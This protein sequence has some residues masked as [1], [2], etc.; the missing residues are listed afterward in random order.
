MKAVFT[1]VAKNYIPLAKNLKESILKIHP[2]LDVFIFVTSYKDEKLESNS[3]LIFLEQLELIK[4][5][6]PNLAFKYNITEFCTSIKPACF[7]YLSTK[8]YEKIIYFD[9]D[10]QV[11]HS[12][13]LIYNELT[14]NFLVITPH[15][16]INE[17]EFTGVRNEGMI[18]FSGVYNL[19]FCAVSTNDEGMKFISWWNNR[20][21]KYSYADKMEGFHT[22]QKWIDLVPCIFD[23]EKIKILKTPGTNAAIWNM[24]ERSVKKVSGKWNIS[25][26]N[27]NIDEP[28]IFYHFSSFNYFD[29]NMPNKLFPAYKEKFPELIPLVSEYYLSLKNHNLKGYLSFKYDFNYFSNGEAINQMHRRIYKR[30]VDQGLISGSTNPFIVGKGSIHEKFKNHKLLIEGNDNVDGMNEKG[31]SGFDKKLKTMNNLMSLFKNIIGIKRYFLLMKFFQRYSRF[32]NQTF[33]ISEFKDKY[34]FHNENR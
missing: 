4:E 15:Y 12:L 22:D 13:D 6:I 5:K 31:L 2:D 23:D 20:L 21:L 28:L 32:E 18:L 9:P 33:L 7:H 30:L 17:L 8:G 26:R 11:Y 1:I 19:G 34:E 24:H 25:Y 16:C 3:E 10:I 14:N 29:D 27:S